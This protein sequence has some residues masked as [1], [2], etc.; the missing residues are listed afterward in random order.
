MI[1][2]DNDTDIVIIEESEEWATL[3]RRPR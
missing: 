3:L 2:L 1:F